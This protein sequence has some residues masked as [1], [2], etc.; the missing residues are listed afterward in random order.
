MNFT[1]RRLDHLSMV[2][3][4]PHYNED[5]HLFY[6]LTEL[7]IY[8]DDRL[9]PSPK[10]GLPSHSTFAVFPDSFSSFEEEA[11]DPDLTSRVREIG[12]RILDDVGWPVYAD[13]GKVCLP[14][15]GLWV[16]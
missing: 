14:P 1:T 15:A 16:S 7:Q 10:E 2:I 8:L 9:R 11:H 3:N 12:D 13:F 5:K 6:F 4:L